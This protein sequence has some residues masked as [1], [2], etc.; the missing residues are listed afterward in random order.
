MKNMK[1]TALILAL[2]LGGL[3]PL[4]A[5]DTNILNNE[6]SRESYAL[7]MFYGHNWQQEGIDVDWNLF[8]RGFQAAQA[9]S[10]TLLTP[11]EM[12]ATLMGLNKKVVA[13]EQQLRAEQAAKDKA[14]GAAFLAANKSKPGVITLPDGLQYKILTPGTGATPQDGDTVTVNYRGTLVDG[15]EFDSSAAHG[16]P[17]QFQ[18]GR[19]IPGWNQ[20]L[21][22]MKAGAK[23]Q[24]FIPPNLAYGAN[25]M[26]PRIPPE[27]T[28]VFNVDLLS[29]QSAHPHPAAAPARASNPPLTSDIIKVPSAAELKKGAKVEIIK[30][31]DLQKYQQSQSAP[32]K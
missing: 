25:G 4:L 22:L 31:Q 20:A 21:K 17:L 9:G 32:A 7:G 13:R 18:V 8:K 11:Q 16:R 10:A 24:L 27:S 3:A 2:S 12:R 28:L 19:V 6:K 1:I 26:P 14:A 29:V 15:T 23:W 5:G 30:P